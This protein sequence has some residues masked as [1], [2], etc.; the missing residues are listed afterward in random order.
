MTPN[1][2]IVPGPVQGDDSGD[3]GHTDHTPV[4]AQQNSL[5]FASQCPQPEMVKL[6]G[7]AQTITKVLTVFETITNRDIW[8]Q[9]V[10]TENNKLY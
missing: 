9:K 7:R 8:R 10:W 4:A 6:N 3:T 1:R 5:T 2:G